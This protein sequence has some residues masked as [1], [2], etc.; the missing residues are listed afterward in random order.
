MCVD[1]LDL[2]T[3]EQARAGTDVTPVSPRPSSIFTFSSIIDD[4]V[5]GPQYRAHSVEDDPVLDPVEVNTADGRSSD[6]CTYS[7]APNFDLP[8]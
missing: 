8:T 3:P 7:P 4:C 5:T 2:S 6:C 1:N